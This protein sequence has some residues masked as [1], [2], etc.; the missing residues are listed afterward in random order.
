MAIVLVNQQDISP[1][2]FEVE[3]IEQIEDFN[4]HPLYIYIYIYCCIYVCYK[5]DWLAKIINK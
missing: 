4:D 5:I 2:L 1:A 3:W